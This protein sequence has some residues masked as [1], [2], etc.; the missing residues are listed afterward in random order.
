[1]KNTVLATAATFTAI[2][3]LSAT[4]ALAG[5]QAWFVQDHRVDLQ[6]IHYGQKSAERSHKEAATQSAPQAEHHPDENNRE[7]DNHAE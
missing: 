7:T 5:G 2:A 3:L 6:P 1:M 4:A